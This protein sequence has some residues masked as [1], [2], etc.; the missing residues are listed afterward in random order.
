MV[1]PRRL[2]LDKRI[3]GDPSRLQVKPIELG[4]DGIVVELQ[5]EPVLV[6]D[7]LVVDPGVGAV[8]GVD[9]VVPPAVPVLEDVAEPA[10]G[11]EDGDGVPGG[12]GRAVGAVDVGGADGVAGGALGDEAVARKDGAA[13]LGAGEDHAPGPGV[14][15]VGGDGGVVGVEVGVV[16]G[17]VGAAHDDELGDFSGDEVP[18]GEVREVVGRR[19]EEAGEVGEETEGDDRD[20]AVFGGGEGLA[21]EGDGIVGLVGGAPGEG[22]AGPVAGDFAGELA[23]LEVAGVEE[24]VVG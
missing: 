1:H 19:V 10:D 3:I 17:G 5:A 18:A 7:V 23:A 24:G 6:A 2:G 16:A 13:Q 4:G 20:A 9:A 11:V 15:D 12:P 21:V 14:D 22:A 8:G